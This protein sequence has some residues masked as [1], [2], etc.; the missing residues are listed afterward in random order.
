ML[1]LL[2]FLLAYATVLFA[3]VLFL[4]AAAFFLLLTAAAGLFSILFGAIAVQKFRRLRRLFQRRL[5]HFVHFR[6]RH[7]WGFDG[8]HRR[9][10][11]IIDG[12][13][14]GLRRF[15]GKGAYPS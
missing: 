4:G 1:I 13:H 10:R 6:L 11:L 14:A 2:G 3:K 9:H 5:G 15:S 7:R 8:R 12:R